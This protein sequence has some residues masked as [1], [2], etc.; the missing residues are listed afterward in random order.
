MPGAFQKE[1][2]HVFKYNMQLRRILPTFSV[3]NIITD[4][5]LHVHIQY[6]CMYVLYR[7]VLYYR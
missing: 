4:L 1:I 2:L 5:K 7:I 3:E 6:M